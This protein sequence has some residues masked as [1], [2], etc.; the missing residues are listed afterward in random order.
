MVDKTDTNF[1]LW[2][3][4]YGYFGFDK[5][6]QKIG[7]T[8]INHIYGTTLFNGLVSNTQSN[9]VFGTTTINKFK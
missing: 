6:Q 1:G 9:Q 5:T 2:N 3:F 7:K 8:T 4:S